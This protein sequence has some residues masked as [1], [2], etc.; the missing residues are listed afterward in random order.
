MYENNRQ[1]LW[2]AA[3]DGYTVVCKALLEGGADPTLADVDGLTPTLAAALYGHVDT[4]LLLLRWMLAEAAMPPPLDSS[5]SDDEETGLNQMAVRERMRQAQVKK[6]AEAA[7]ARDAIDES[8]HPGSLPPSALG[9]S[10]GAGLALLL[11]AA[12]LRHSAALLELAL[13][14][15]AALPQPAPLMVLRCASRCGL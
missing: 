9:P 13:R 1:A 2:F 3:R 8:T 14:L 10:P 15:G 7:A 5:S 4:A 12:V 11:R 6:L